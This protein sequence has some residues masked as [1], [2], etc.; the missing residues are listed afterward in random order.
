MVICMLNYREKKHVL[1]LGGKRGK[2]MSFGNKDSLGEFSSV[3]KLESKLES[4]TLGWRLL[5][6]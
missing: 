5:A 2:K 4:T 1:Y 6:S 3:L